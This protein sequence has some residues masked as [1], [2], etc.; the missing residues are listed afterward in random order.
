MLTHPTKYRNTVEYY[1]I[2]VYYVE[3]NMTTQTK[4]CCKLKL[5]L[6]KNTKLSQKD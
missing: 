3:Q 6:N 2:H 5:D 1:R 4:T